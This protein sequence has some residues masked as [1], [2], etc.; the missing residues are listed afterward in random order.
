MFVSVDDP[1]LGEMTVQA[2]VAR[3]S[4]SPGRVEHLGRALGADNEA[5]YRDLLGIDDERLADLRSAGT[6]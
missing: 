6:I 4:E 3:L 2:P 5:V 1:D